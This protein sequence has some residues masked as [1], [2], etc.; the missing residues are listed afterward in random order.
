[1]TVVDRRPPSTASLDD[2][3]RAVCCYCHKRL[4]WHI[5]GWGYAGSGHFCNVKCAAE[6]ADIKVIGTADGY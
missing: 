5:N 4:R 6:W 1:M 2:D 3:G